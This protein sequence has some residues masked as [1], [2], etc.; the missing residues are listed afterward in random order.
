MRCASDTKRSTTAGVWLVVG[1]Q[2]SPR[3]LS[4]RGCGYWSS[5][6]HG[7]WGVLGGDL[8]ASSLPLVA[9]GANG[10][11]GTALSTSAGGLGVGSAGA[12]GDDA[13]AVGRATAGGLGAVEALAAPGR[14]AV[15]DWYGF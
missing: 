7:V 13:G 14:W 11:S 9:C 4:P 2:C 6:S 12:A 5:A 1:T 15:G 10:P 8:A 3:P